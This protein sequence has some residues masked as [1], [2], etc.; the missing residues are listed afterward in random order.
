MRV[1]R[2]GCHKSG[3]F[4][5]ETTRVRLRL[6]PRSVMHARDSLR[7][8]FEPRESTASTSASSSST[9]R[10]AKQLA[11]YSFERRNDSQGYR[12]AFSTDQAGTSA[13]AFANASTQGG[14]N[15]TTAVASPAKYAQ[16]P[17][18]VPLATEGRLQTL[19]QVPSRKAPH[20]L[21]NSPDAH[22]LKRRVAPPQAGSRI[23]IR[24]GDDESEVPSPQ[25][26]PIS[27]NCEQLKLSR[28]DGT[29]PGGMTVRQKIMSRGF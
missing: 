24:W 23:T 28:A 2:Y 25:A 11:F 18:R 29:V 16:P 26:F 8:Y 27:L 21:K 1:I 14:S 19:S 6:W 15:E 22:R 7:G 12:C 10:K 4:L 13:V 9:H 20:P 5:N 17:R 3:K